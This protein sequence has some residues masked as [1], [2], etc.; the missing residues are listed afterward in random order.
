MTDTGGSHADTRDM[1]MVHTLFRREFGALPNLVQTCRQVTCQRERPSDPPGESPIDVW[2]DPLR[3]E[4]RSYPENS[5]RTGTRSSYCS[6]GA[7]SASVFVSF[8]R[9]YGTGPPPRLAAAHISCLGEARG[10]GVDHQQSRR[11]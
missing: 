3:S 7:R 4:S 2:H 11:R 5:L 10:R 6:A 8:R 1:Y 9:V